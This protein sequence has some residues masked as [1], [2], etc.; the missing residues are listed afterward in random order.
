MSPFV[1]MNMIINNLLST[2]NYPNSISYQ[3]S[4]G[5]ICDRHVL[6]FVFHFNDTWYNIV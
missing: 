6:W 4:R 2:P 3:Q 1:E 5:E